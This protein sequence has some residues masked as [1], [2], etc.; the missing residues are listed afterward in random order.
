MTADLRTVY[1]PVNGVAILLFFPLRYRTRVVAFQVIVCSF[2][3]SRDICPT[4]DGGVTSSNDTSDS[5]AYQ[6]RREE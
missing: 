6:T 3:R 4:I 2:V 1:G 5:A